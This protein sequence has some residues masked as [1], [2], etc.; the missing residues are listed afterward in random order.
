[1]TLMLA[2]PAG[3]V[4]VGAAAALA[5]F[6][7]TS[8]RG[9]DALWLLTELHRVGRTVRR[10]IAAA[11]QGVSR[12]RA[13]KQGPVTLSDVSEMIDVVRLGLS[14]G[15]SFDAALEL[16]CS[17]SPSRLAEIMGSA[18]LSWRVGASTRD[19]AL[20]AAARRAD[21]R[22][23]DSFASAVSQA[24]AMG[25]PL[26]E[27]LASQ[28]AEIR[29]AHLAAVEREIERAPVKLIIPTGTLIL[30]AQ[31]L[32]ILGPLLAAGGMV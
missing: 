10:A 4:A 2:G 12:A 31:L 25:A 7:V 28:G 22:V 14:A 6:A 23:L 1:M 26:V 8:W 19:D 13:R 3:P 15:L 20:A 9:P 30:P 18:E 17:E 27:T 21:V 24:L 16:Y 11:V 5:T 29:A 32:S